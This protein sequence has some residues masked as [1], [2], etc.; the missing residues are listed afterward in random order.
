MSGP[1]RAR[2]GGTA[3][4]FERDIELVQAVERLGFDEAWIGE[5]HSGGAQTICSP[6]LFLARRGDRLLTKTIKG[7]RPIGE[8]VDDVKD[9]AEHVMIVDLERNDLSPVC[10]NGTRR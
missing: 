7:T 5:H 4:A 10:G 2:R 3:R 1:F 9:A 8:D 6:E